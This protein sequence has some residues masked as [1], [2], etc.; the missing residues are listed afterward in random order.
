MKCQFAIYMLLVACFACSGTSSTIS[1]PVRAR[2]EEPAA[3]QAV[4]GAP[5]LYR[6][7]DEARAEA[8]AAESRG[9][10]LA[11][12]DHATRARLLLDAAIAETERLEIEEQRL[13]VD[14]ES[15][16]IEEQLAE[17]E[18]E[19]REAREAAV[20]AETQQVAREQATSA[21]E[22]AISDERRR[23]RSRSSARTQLHREAA[24]VLQRRAS[25]YVAAARAM[26]ATRTELTEVR[27][28]IE[29][30]RTESDVTASI[31]QA[32]EAVRMSFVVLG[33]ARSRRDGPTTGEINA[34][35]DAATEYGFAPQQRRAGLTLRLEGL[36][37]GSQLSPS[38]DEHLLRVAALIQAHPHGAVQVV[39]HGSGATQ[40]APLVERAISAAGAGSERLSSEV[41]EPSADAAIEVRFLSY[42]LGQ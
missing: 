41:G 28:R 16:E 20:L 36:L 23:Y 6:Q 11:A 5:E 9:D 24:L 38:A 29:S 25:L 19:E 3:V 10:L 31:A 21:F 13:A 12:G 35:R 4:N 14:S 17:A 37:Q 2:F 32:D 15:L 22:Q 27:N 39:V 18:R 26:G 40:Q 1:D 34:L 33:T 30:S 8:Q 42:S 7:A